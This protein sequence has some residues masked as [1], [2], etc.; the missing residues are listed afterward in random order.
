MLKGSPDLKYDDFLQ[1]V[2]GIFVKFVGECLTDLCDGF[3][4]GEVD[5]FKWIESNIRAYHTKHTP[6]NLQMLVNVKANQNMAA[7]KRAYEEY[8]ASSAEV[9]APTADAEMDGDD[10]EKG[11]SAEERRAKFLAKHKAMLDGDQAKAEAMDE[12]NPPSR[13]YSS[14]CS[15]TTQKTLAKDEA[16]I[17]R[18]AFMLESQKRL[19]ALSAEMELRNAIKRNLCTAGSLPQMKVEETMGKEDKLP[20]ELVQAYFDMQKKC[21]KFRLSEDNDYKLATAPGAPN[22]TD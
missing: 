11:E 15:L 13:A 5:C 6:P 14:T 2:K 19:Q 16:D 1:L 4:E 22:P 10:S 8:K 21:I 7:I 17:S 9:T 18:K 20:N 3:K 12:Q